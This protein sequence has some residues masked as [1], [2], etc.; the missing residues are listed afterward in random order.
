MLAFG[1]LTLFVN[2]SLVKLMLFNPA[3]V[4]DHSQTTLH[5]DGAPYSIEPS[6]SSQNARS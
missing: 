2:L 4:S 3:M 1:Q 5:S 6:V